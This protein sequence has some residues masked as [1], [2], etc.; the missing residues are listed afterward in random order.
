MK[1]NDLPDVTVNWRGRYT[2]IE[3]VRA[4][5]GRAKQLVRL[6]RISPACE[7]ACNSDPIRVLCMSLINHVNRLAGKGSRFARKMTPPKFHL[8]ERNQYAG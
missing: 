4:L 3:P 6:R 7:N 2:S 5:G 1:H 8:F